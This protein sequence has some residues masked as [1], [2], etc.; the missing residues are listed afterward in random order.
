VVRFLNDDVRYQ[1]ENIRIDFRHAQRDT[2]RPVLR[3]LEAVGG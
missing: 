3:T 2:D 1:T